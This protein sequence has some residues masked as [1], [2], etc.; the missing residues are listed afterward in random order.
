MNQSLLTLKCRRFFGKSRYTVTGKGLEVTRQFLLWKKSVIVPWE[1]LNEKVSVE[2][3]DLEKQFVESIS[4]FHSGKITEQEFHR[5]FQVLKFSSTL[6][7]SLKG[8]FYN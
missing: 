6:N 4:L 8:P 1:K 7:E 5:R 2:K 3:K